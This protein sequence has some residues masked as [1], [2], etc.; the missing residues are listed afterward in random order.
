M[1]MTM[2]GLAAADVVATNWSDADT[3]GYITLYMPDLDQERQN[4]LPN[5]GTCHCGPTSEADLLAWIATHGFPEYA[6]GQR[7][8]EAQSNYDDATEII[9]EITN[10]LGSFWDGTGANGWCGTSQDEI[11]ANLN[12]RISDKFTVT[13]A[14]R[15][16]SS[17]QSVR[18]SDM[19][20]M[21]DD[22]AVMMLLYGRYNW[23]QMTDS[24]RLDG[25]PGGHFVAMSLLSSMDGE[26]GLLGVRDPADPRTNTVQ[27]PFA[28]RFWDYTERS[29]YQNYLG[30]NAPV[31]QVDEL[32]NGTPP[33]SSSR[34][35][36]LDG[37]IAIT[38]R[39]CYTWDEFDDGVRVLI[40]TGP[41]WNDG[42]PEELLDIGIQLREICPGPWGRNIYVRTPEGKLLCLRRI[43]RDLIEITPPDLQSPIEG[44][45]IDAFERIALLSDG[46]LQ[47]YLLG[48][49]DQQI[50]IPS[51]GF[52]G[53][54]VMWI[55][56]NGPQDGEWR[57]PTAAVLGGADRR[58]G[59]MKFA[60]E[61][62]PE[63][64]TYSL[65]DF[66]KETTRMVHGG[67][68]DS[69][70]MLTDGQVRRLIINQQGVIEELP[71]QL[72]GV[73]FVD[74]LEV[75][76]RGR[77]VVASEGR[78]FA[79]KQ[80]KNLGWAADPEHIFAD[81]P[82]KR[83]LMLSHSRSNWDPRQM[84]GPPRQAPDPMLSELPVKLDCPGDLTLDGMVDGGDLT[85]L[86]AAWDTERSIAD[87]D[88]NGLVD[89]ADLAILLGRWGLCKK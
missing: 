33:S 53:T 52:R 75:D 31:M 77:L 79:F 72:P 48:R 45:A 46:T 88:R 10:E 56:W 7:D 21:G 27:D 76:D 42:L 65:P 32:Y 19:A 35:R 82:V 78:V 60:A 9:D 41:I 22:G 64:T 86:L 18:F 55:P 6:P 40:P 84:A 36:L 15:N 24:R 5:N 43:D 23:T 87:I 81:L 13:S 68:P 37:Y 2:S 39:R 30:G 73:T 66:V 1:P 20:Q 44:L 69:F 59:L 49:M 51:L 34:M 50:Q 57:M 47:L 26:V 25:R 8:W 3:Y 61:G 14:L 67:S 85:I 71:M 70:F 58:L 74:D 83:R 12:A 38:P 11:F 54:D 62:P 80:T 29:I 89:G 16:L 63:L 28:N 17:G 4:D